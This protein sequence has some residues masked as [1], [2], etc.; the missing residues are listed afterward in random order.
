M[1]KFFLNLFISHNHQ[2][3]FFFFFNISSTGEPASSSCGNHGK[4]IH[5]VSVL[6]DGK[7]RQL[8]C[9]SPIHLAAKF[10]LACIGFF[11]MA[12]L[13]EALKFY[14]E[15]LL[16]KSQQ[17]NQTVVKNSDGEVT[18]RSVKLSPLQ[19]MLS[20]PH[21]VQTLLHILQVFTSYILML[22]IMLCNLWLVLAICLGAAVGYFLFGWMRKTS[23]NDMGE[24]C[25]WYQKFLIAKG[26]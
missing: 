21:L 4:Q 6:Q 14:R 9:Q 13:Y 3:T 12:V 20:G 24:C 23:C 19:E 25:Y 8:N 5:Q 1:I 11:L 16:L 26:V 10:T 17:A 2:L 15:D 18:R 22:I 7:Q